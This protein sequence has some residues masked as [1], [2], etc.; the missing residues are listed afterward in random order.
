MEQ[1]TKKPALD[2]Q[3]ILEIKN[4]KTYYRS[5]K[6]DVPA[7]DGVDL[8]LY[9]GEIVGIVG[10]SGCGKSTVVRSLMGLMNPATSRHEDGSAL[11]KGKDQPDDRSRGYIRVPDVRTYRSH[12]GKKRGPRE[13]PA[14]AL[15]RCQC[16]RSDS[17]GNRGRTYTQLLY[18]SETR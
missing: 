6:G 10:E 4:L 15:D 2:I 12:Y 14:H 13:L 11:F 5:R 3:P 1:E 7:V 17:V 9:P 16:I 18:V 8:T